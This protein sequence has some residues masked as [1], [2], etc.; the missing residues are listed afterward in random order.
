MF[1]NANTEFTL[2]PSFSQSQHLYFTSKLKQ[3]DSYLKDYTY[4]YI[5]PFSVTGRYCAK[6]ESVRRICTA[7]SYSIGSFTKLV[8]AR[9]RMCVRVYVRVCVCVCVLISS[10]FRLSAFGS[11]FAEDRGEECDMFYILASHGRRIAG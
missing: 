10:L 4:R 8:F 9:A 11:R 2:R 1:L 7:V 5:L 6:I 3:L